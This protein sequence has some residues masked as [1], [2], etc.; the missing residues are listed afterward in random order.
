MKKNFTFVKAMG[1]AAV[2]MLVLV[3]CYKIAEVIMPDK[4]GPNEE[5]TITSSLVWDDTN[6]VTSYGCYAICLPE[7]WEANFPA[8]AICYYKDGAKIASEGFEPNEIFT[9]ICNRFYAREGYVWYGFSTEKGQRGPG[10]CDRVV[11]NTLVKTNDV[12]GTYVI[13]QIFGDEEDNFEKY[14]GSETNPALNCRLCHAGT[15]DAQDSPADGQRSSVENVFAEGSGRITLEG[16]PTAVDAVKL[17]NVKMYALGG[18]RLRVNADANS[19]VT[20]Y[21]LKGNVVARHAAINGVAELSLNSGIAVIK[22]VSGN[23]QITKK[24]VVR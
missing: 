18:G 23:K 1:L 17:D 3:S 14:V 15:F 20:A 12:A 6:D 24:V 16:E 8:E 2:A 22:V 11:V 13:D 19:I 5:F 9:D 10:V 21:D 7:G 4:V